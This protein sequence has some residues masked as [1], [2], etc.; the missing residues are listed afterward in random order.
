MI[1]KTNPCIWNDKFWDFSKNLLQP[2]WSLND[3]NQITT[4]WF[5]N[6]QIIAAKHYRNKRCKN[7]QQGVFNSGNQAGSQA[8]TFVSKILPLTFNLC[9][10]FRCQINMAFLFNFLI[11]KTFTL[12]QVHNALIMA[13]LPVS[14]WQHWI[15]N[16]SVQLRCYTYSLIFLYIGLHNFKM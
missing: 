10:K 13:L 12:Q 1:S 6:W 5:V 14:V 4:N 11:N 15:F 7:V 9:F 3:Q 2:K 8:M 16:S